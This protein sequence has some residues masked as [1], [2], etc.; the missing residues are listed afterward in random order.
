VSGTAIRLATGDPSSDP[1][2]LFGEVRLDGMAHPAMARA[3]GQLVDDVPAADARA[4]PTG[5]CWIE[6]LLAMTMVVR[7]VLGLARQLPEYL[8]AG[9]RVYMVISLRSRDTLLP[10]PP[11]FPAH[12]S[13]RR[14]ASAAASWNAWTCRRLA[15]MIG[16]GV[17]RQA[18]GRGAPGEG[19]NRD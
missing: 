7:P 14:G 9:G 8:V 19:R 1:L 2:R 10:L 11:L 15:R 13:W 3:P 4:A 18:H 17:E 6:V 16:P 12:E 5:R